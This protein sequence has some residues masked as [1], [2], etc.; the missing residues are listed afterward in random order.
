MLSTRPDKPMATVNRILE[1]I[2]I[3]GAENIEVVKVLGW[4]CV[5]KKNE[6]E[7]GDLC[8][9]F[10]IGSLFPSEYPRVEFLKGKPLK[11]KKILNTLSQGLVA[12]MSWLQDF[13][14]DI[15]TFKEGDDVT[16]HFSIMKFVESDEA[17][18]YVTKLK[19]DGTVSSSQA[20]FPSYIP[21]TDE[22]LIQNIPDAVNWIKGKDIVVTRKEDGCSATY[23]VKDGC[24]YLCSRNFIVDPNHAS[25]HYLA[26]LLRYNLQ[27]KLL[28]LGRNIAVQG[29][30]I[31]P[32]VSGNR[33]KLKQL[34]YRVF[35]VYDIDAQCYFS[36][37]EVMELCEQLELDHV[38]V[39]FRGI[40]DD[41]EIFASVDSLLGYADTVEYE[42]KSPAEGIVIKEN[43]RVP[44]Q[45]TLPV[46]M[47]F[48][49]MLPLIRRISF[50]VI[51][52]RYLLKNNL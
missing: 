38:P 42:G 14:L 51:S 25:P 47:P 39:L 13:G 21:K 31:G 48:E 41:N 28:G 27:E 34:M 29:E 12:Q 50:K 52:N 18:Q 17:A 20:Q 11:T 10:M 6:F 33:L 5:A 16:E 37:D 4:M 24:F 7:V 30:I 9:Y 46:D 8:V 22:E 23:F 36:H 3:A 2:P 49:E 32:K 15:A 45:A 26:P 35:N 43:R 19:T 44:N 1:K 40:P